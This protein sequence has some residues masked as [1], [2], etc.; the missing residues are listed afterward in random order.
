MRTATALVTLALSAG[1]APAPGEDPDPIPEA[2]TASLPAIDRDLVG[3]HVNAGKEGQHPDEGALCSLSPPWI[4]TL[5]YRDEIAETTDVLRSYRDRGAHVLLL[6]NQES[7][8]VPFPESPF[9][10]GDHCDF[11]RDGHWETELA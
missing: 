11:A 5:V 6:V 1:C 10:A 4:R 2:T 3:L 9:Y 8:D 7:V